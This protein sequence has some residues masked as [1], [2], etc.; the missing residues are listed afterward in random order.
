MARYRIDGI[1]YNIDEEAV[2]DNIVQALEELRASPA[3]QEAVANKDNNPWIPFK[4]EDKRTEEQALDQAV[5]EMGPIERGTR[6]ITQGIPEAGAQMITGVGAM[7]PGAA[8]YGLERVLGA[9]DHQAQQAMHETQKTFTYEPRSTMGRVMG[10]I[11]GHAWDYTKQKIGELAETMD[12]RSGG[13]FVPSEVS[14]QL[15]PGGSPAFRTAGEAA[16][17][18]RMLTK[19][20]TGS[21]DRRIEARKYALGEEARKRQAAMQQQELAQHRAIQESDEVALNEFDP[22]YPFA[23]QGEPPLRGTQGTYQKAQDYLKTRPDNVDKLSLEERLKIERD[24]LE[25]VQGTVGADPFNQDAINFPLRLEVLNQP[26]VRMNVQNFIRNVEELEKAG[27]TEEAAI[28]RERFALYMEKYGIKDYRDVVG[29]ALDKK[30]EV[31]GMRRFYEG[32]T[33]DRGMGVEKTMGNEFRG[34][35]SRGPTE[36]NQLGGWIDESMLGEA[37]K[38]K[39]VGGQFAA[40]RTSRGLSKRFGQGGAVDPGV[41]IEGIKKLM[42]SFGQIMPQKGDILTT[43]GI[44]GIRKGLKFKVEKLGLTDQSG[45]PAIVG[46]F[47][48]PARRLNQVSQKQLAKSQDALAEIETKIDAAQDKYDAA[49]ARGDDIEATR[50]DNELQSLQDAK[51]YHNSWINELSGVQSQRW[52]QPRAMSL[53]HLD[54]FSEYPKGTKLPGVMDRLGMQNAQGGTG[55]KGFKQGGALNLN[56]FKEDYKDFSERVKKAAGVPISDDVIKAMWDEQN[57]PKKVTSDPVQQVISGVPGVREALKDLNVDQRPLVIGKDGNKNILDEGLKAELTGEDISGSKLARLGRQLV[58]GGQDLARLT[59]NRYLKYGVDLVGRAMTNIESIGRKIMHSKQYGAIEAINGLPKEDMVDLWKRIIRPNIGVRDLS[60]QDLHEAGL[61]QKQIDAYMKMR[62]ATNYIFEEVN[63]VLESKGMRPIERLPGYFP[64]KFV[65]DFYVQVWSDANK[66]NLIGLYSA[67]NRAHVQRVIDHIERDYKD[68]GWTVGDIQERN[69]WARKRDSASVWNVMGD[70]QRV[71]KEGDPRAEILADLLSKYENDSM[72]YQ[73]GLFQHFKQRKGIEGS[74][75]RDPLKDDLQNAKDAFKA[76]NDYM[77]QSVEFI[78]FN[79]ISKDMNVLLNSDQFPGMP[80]AQDYMRQYW[81]RARGVPSKFAQMQ[82]DIVSAIAHEFGFS[83]GAVKAGLGKIKPQL[84]LMMLGYNT[85][86]FLIAQLL[87]PN[88]FLLQNIMSLKARGLDIGMTD[89][90]N[91]WGKGMYHAYQLSK[92]RSYMEPHARRALEWAEENQVV[93]PHMFEDIKTDIEKARSGALGW[94]N[95]EKSIRWTEKKARIQTFMTY[96][97]LLDRKELTFREQMEMAANLTRH[98]MVDYR[99][100]EKPLLYQNMGILGDVVSPLKTFAHNYYTQMAVGINEFMKANWQDKP[101]YAVPV[102]LGLAMQGL[103]S[104]LMGLPGRED[105]DMIAGWI[106]HL[107]PKFP[108]ATQVL[109]QSKMPN[110]VT[111]GVSA[112]TGMDMSPTFSAQSLVPDKASEL[113]PLPSK[114]W[115]MIKAIPNMALE[116][117]K[118]SVW[119]AAQ[120]WLPNAYQGGLELAMRQGTMVP[121]PK[122]HMHGDVRRPESLTSKEWMARF[123]GSRS[124]DESKERTATYEQKKEEADIKEEKAQVLRRAYED[125]RAGKPVGKYAQ[126]VGKYGMTVNEFHNAMIAMHKERITTEKQRLQGLN[127]Q[128]PGQQRK[129]SDVQRYK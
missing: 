37:D 21:L 32:E 114:V 1:L 70:I 63:K 121:N 25:S 27:K 94:I 89:V 127:P 98:T 77:Q 69:P 29:G 57:N 58:S 109:L 60:I 88:Q 15:Q 19:P 52:S 92:D 35:P 128:S 26:H 76:L 100:F 108:T 115:D 11:G 33:T 113:L 119:Q 99:P 73:S 42:S 124:I 17:E 9:D 83:G 6:A 112:I 93:E 55:T 78:E 56:I 23:Q 49:K 45:T 91:A 14:N 54:Q 3:H 120:A 53:E 34:E 105:L 68:E 38:G 71:L 123:L 67:N 126:Q 51:A 104:G 7:I 95:G 75:G 87:Q 61:N 107:Y 84:L 13:P 101:Q 30:G 39:R 64:G 66:N 110:Y 28:M 102:I 36:F 86:R 81:D 72:R 24:R 31:G 65:G 122:T 20:L 96:A 5:N 62:A 90:V 50:I 125:W 117:T 46:R 2:G 41:F 22:N 4:Y 12:P 103:F 44:G 129:Y 82:Y 80:N 8:R 74:A 116:R 43:S 40:N 79:K 16:F 48:E 97:D 59:N 118:A 111:H 10:D 85:P 47:L 106:K 18:G